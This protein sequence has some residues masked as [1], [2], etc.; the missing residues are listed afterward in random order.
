MAITS[1]TNGNNI[2]QWHITLCG[3]NIYHHGNNI[4]LHKIATDQVVLPS[5]T[6]S[7]AIT[8]ATLLSYEIN[9]YSVLPTSNTQ[10]Q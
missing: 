1:A 7:M 4:S 3:F 2:C 8:S 5:T 10:G 6:K 9:I